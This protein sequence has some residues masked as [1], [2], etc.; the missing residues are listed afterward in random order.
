MRRIN[1]M[2]NNSF[3][4]IDLLKQRRKVETLE[5]VLFTS[6]KKNLKKGIAIGSFFLIISILICLASYTQTKIYKRE[7]QELE[8]STLLHDNLKA[9]IKKGLFEIRSIQKFN[10]NLANAILGLRSIPEIIYEIGALVPQDSK[11]ESIKINKNILNINGDSE[12]QLNLDLI[13]TYIIGLKNSPFIKNETVVLV[14][15]KQDEKIKNK[16]EDLSI[17]NIK[18]KITAE[19]IAEYSKLNKR[20]MNKIKSKGLAQRIKIIES[21]GLIE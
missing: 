7:I 4:R 8:S 9:K 10:K 20:R 1:K 21:E 3:I 14:N 15:A 5:D 11:L 18:F 13:N 2:E 6:N 16:N 19:F 12:N 17:D